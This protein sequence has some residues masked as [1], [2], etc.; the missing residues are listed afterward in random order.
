M[1]EKTQQLLNA[2]GSGQYDDDLDQVVVAIKERRRTL[3]AR[4]T[5]DFHKDDRVVFSNLAR[6]SGLR[7]MAGTIEETP[8]ENRRRTKL[9]VR[10]DEGVH[11][12]QIYSCPASILEKA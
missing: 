6:H 12:G 8:R 3:A 4:K 1:T 10:V 11:M 5:Q 7:G 9:A 2:I